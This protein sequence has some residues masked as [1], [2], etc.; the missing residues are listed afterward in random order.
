MR[1]SAGRRGRGGVSLLLALA[2][3]GAAILAIAQEPAPAVDP[4]ANRVVGTPPFAAGEKLRYALA[5]LS[6]GGGEMSIETTGP[7]PYRNRPAYTIRLDAASNSFFSKFYVVRDTILSVV[8]AE[9]FE[10]MKFEKHTK[11]GRHQK[12]Q[13]AIFDLDK[14]ETFWKG[15]RV[16]LPGHVVDTLSAVWYLR[17]LPLEVGKPIYLDAINNGKLYKLRVDVVAAETIKVP[18]GTY[19]TLRLEPKMEGGFFKAKDGKLQ[20]WMTDDAQRIPVQIRTYLPLGHIT[21]ALLRP[22]QAAPSGQN[23]FPA[24]KGAVTVPA[25]AGAVDAAHPQSGAP[26]TAAK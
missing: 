12:D 19:K 25:G 9:R 24:E 5:W 6:V 11:E 20:I 18:A 22:D 1:S 21:A 13:V 16:K 26:A 7:A 4:A 10:S 23:A 14:R 2:L 3:S 17:L 8:D 15:E